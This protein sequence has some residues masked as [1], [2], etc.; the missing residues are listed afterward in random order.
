MFHRTW[1]SSGEAEQIHQHLFEH[2]PLTGEK[3]VDSGTEG[4]GRE[5]KRK[6]KE[7]PRGA[8]MARFLGEER[9]ARTQVEN[10]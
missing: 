10:A 3:S 9:C 7:T 6:S 4:S 5:D 8:L 1:W 2:W